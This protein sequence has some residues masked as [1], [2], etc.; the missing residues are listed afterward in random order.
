MSS[1]TA[2]FATRSI[3]TCTITV[4]CLHLDFCAILFLYKIQRDRWTA[5]AAVVC[6]KIETAICQCTQLKM[7]AKEIQ[8]SE[9][10]SCQCSR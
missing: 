6:T 2:I 10:H 8:H 9:K 5:Y 1:F 3:D 4:Y 7:V